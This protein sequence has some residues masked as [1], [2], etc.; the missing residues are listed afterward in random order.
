MWQFALQLGEIIAFVV[1]PHFA[2]S[3]QKQINIRL[4]YARLGGE[5]SVDGPL[6]PLCCLKHPQRLTRCYDRSIL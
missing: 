1:V 2:K 6:P 4:S 5:R 3:F